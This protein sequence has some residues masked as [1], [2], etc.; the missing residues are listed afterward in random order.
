MAGRMAWERG[1]S[2][3]G[4]EDGEGR[5][6]MRGPD[7]GTCCSCGQREA[8]LSWHHVPGLPGLPGLPGFPGLPVACSGLSRLVVALLPYRKLISWWSDLRGPWSTLIP[9]RVPRAHHGRCLVHCLASTSEQPSMAERP[10]LAETQ[11][12]MGPRIDDRRREHVHP[13]SGPYGSRIH[14]VHLPGTYGSS[15]GMHYF[16]FSICL[17]PGLMIQLFM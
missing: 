6:L 11:P 9:D 14:P 17:H 8:K 12:I 7:G 16:L 1:R 2:A 3:A 4:A 10:S 15:H 13:P 5:R